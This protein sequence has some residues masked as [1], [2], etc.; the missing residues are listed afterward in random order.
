MEA[1]PSM[2]NC[3]RAPNTECLVC[4]KSIYRRLIEIDSRNGR[5]YCSRRCW[6]I[7]QRKINLCKVCGK[8]ILGGFIELHVA[9]HVQINIGLVFFTRVS[10]VVGK[11][12]VF[13]GQYL[14]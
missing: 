5:V 3:K 11:E 10:W 12:S 8:I 4:K 14:H 9:V 6:G 1:W 2:E 7:S 13:L